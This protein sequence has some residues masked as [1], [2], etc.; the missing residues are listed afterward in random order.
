MMSRF[1]GQSVLVL[2]LGSITLAADD[3]K[4]NDT[5]ISYYRQIRPIFQV[6][7]QGCH[8]PAK[9]GGDYVMTTFDRLLRGGESETPAIVPGEVDESYLLEL[10]TPDGGEAQM[11]QGKPPLNDDEITLIRRWVATGAKDD[12][13]RNA[14]QRYDMEHPPV[15]TLPPVVTSVQYSP[16]GQL[17][18]VA[19]FHEVLLHKADGS[20]LVARLVG[21]AERIESVQFSLDGQRLAVTGGLPAR[22]G[23][24]Q[25]WDVAVPEDGIDAL[26]PKLLLSVPIT[27]DTIYGGSWSPDGRLIAFGCGDNSLLAID[28]TTGEQVLFQGVHTDLVRETVFSL[29]GTKLVSVSRDMTVKLTEVATERFI[30]NITSITPGAL[31]GGV[32]AVARHPHRD[33]IVIGGADGVPKVYR[34]ERLTERRIGD[35]A[36][37]IRR[38][39]PY[40]ADCSASP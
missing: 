11:P 5:S 13:P 18:A 33:E 29:D 14:R 35:D 34:L 4:P 28:A 39:R 7:C 40:R 10:I 12:T 8:Q 3:V 23:E 20:G 31:K 30:D 17:L 1:L 21:V 2:V 27:F 24:V 37:L 26:K 36:N 9:A 15:Y 6:H 25:V 22:M 16:D 19:G 32:N 38:C